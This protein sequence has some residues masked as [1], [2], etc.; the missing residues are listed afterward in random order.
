MGCEENGLKCLKIRNILEQQQVS[1][2]ENDGTL[3]KRGSC[4]GSTEE[5]Q[6]TETDFEFVVRKKGENYLVVTQPVYVP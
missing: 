3:F 2:S 6:P 5:Q 4:C 1:P